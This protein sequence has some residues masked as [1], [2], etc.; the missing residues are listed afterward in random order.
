[1][2]KASEATRVTACAELHSTSCGISASAERIRKALPSWA[3]PSYLADR[4]SPAL[5][6]VLA[7]E[8]TAPGDNARADQALL[9]LLARH[10]AN[11]LRDRSS[12]LGVRRAGY[13]LAL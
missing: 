12:E 8:L 10:A 7:G 13:R 1:M 5:S 11:L 2:A 9:K 3:G 6:L 4:P